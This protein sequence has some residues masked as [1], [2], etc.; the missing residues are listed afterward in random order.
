MLYHPSVSF[1]LSQLLGCHCWRK[2]EAAI[3]GERLRERER[4]AKSYSTFILICEVG[5]FLPCFGHHY[6]VIDL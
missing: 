3:V 2:T 4:R 6:L 1:T 5:F